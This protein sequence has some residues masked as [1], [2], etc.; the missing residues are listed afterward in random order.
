[1]QKFLKIPITATGETSQLLAVNGIVIVEQA[2]TT[3]VTVTYGGAAAQDVATITLGAAMAANDVTV[4]DRIQDSI[5]SAL[6]TAW[7]KP[8]YDVNVS[9]LTNAAGDPVTVTGIAVA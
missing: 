6:Q 1:M 9:D 2:S 4:R 7:N 3:T 5:E 8:V